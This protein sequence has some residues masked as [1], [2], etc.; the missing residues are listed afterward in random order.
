MASSKIPTAPQRE[1]FDTRAPRRGSREPNE[2]ARRRSESDP[3]RT[4]TAQ[5]SPSSRQICAAPQ[6]ERRAQDKFAHHS[7]RLRVLLL[8]SKL[9]FSSRSCGNVL[10]VLLWYLKVAICTELKTTA[11]GTTARAP[12]SRRT[13]TEPQRER[14]FDVKRARL[15]SNA[16]DPRRGS[17]EPS[18]FARRRSESDRTRAIPAEGS[19][20]PRQIRTAPQRE[21]SDTHDPRRGFTA[22]KTDS[23]GATA[24]AIRHARSPQRVHRDQDRFARRRSESDPTRTILAEGSPRPRQM[25]TAP[26]RERSD[27]HDPRKWFT[28]TKT[29]SQG[30]TARA[31]SS[32]QTRT[33]PQRER[34]DTHDPRRGS[35]EPSKFARR[36]SESDP[37]RT[38][39]AEGSPRP[40][41]IRTAPQRE[42]SD[43]H[44]PRRGFTA[45]KTDSRGA[46]A[47]AIRHAR[48]PERVHRDQDRF[49]RRHSESDPTRTIP[50]EG[51]PRPRQI[52]TPPARK[53]RR[54]KNREEKEEK[55]K[56]AS[57]LE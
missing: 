42:R 48:S 3:T 7:E 20:R 38:I 37:T 45:T 29:D 44:D 41:Q 12:S 52:R 18:K 24:R 8:S 23:H 6:R 13:R 5:A 51:S 30:A 15:T 22:T 27:T 32:R 40:R 2:F 50:A 21:R 39:P 56:L 33:A 1:R 36:H 47:R 25:R 17:R 10:R 49:A 4:I 34:S 9:R 31:P 11:R 14:N 26:Q 43:T 35:R 57:D 46:T 19:P 55:E 54:T 28:A 53:R 16:H